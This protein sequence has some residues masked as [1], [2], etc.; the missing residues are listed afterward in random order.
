[1][2]ALISN[3]FLLQGK[4]YFTRRENKNSDKAT[5][6]RSDKG[7]KISQDEIN[8]AGSYYDSNTNTIDMAE[9]HDLKFGPNYI[10]KKGASDKFMA[11]SQTK[12]FRDAYK[13]ATGKEIINFAEAVEAAKNW[14]TIKLGENENGLNT[15]YDEEKHGPI[16]KY[17]I[18]QQGS[19]FDYLQICAYKNEGQ[20]LFKKNK[21]KG[22][23]INYASQGDVEERVPG[24]AHGRVYLPM[25]PGLADQTQVSW[26]Q[27]SMNALDSVIAGS[28]GGA[29]EGASRSSL[30]S[31]SQGFGNAA[32][33]ISEIVKDIKGPDVAA[34]AAGKMIGKNLLARGTGRAVN[35]NLELLF[36]GP[37]LRTFA[38]SY[39]F[40]PREEKESLMIKKII[41]FF[42]KAMSPRKTK[43]KI[44][45]ESPDIFKLKYIYGPR[46]GQHPFLN[47]I[48]M[49]SLQSFDVQYTPDGSYST[50]DDGSMTAYQVSLQ[51]GELNPI[52]QNDQDK[53]NIQ[54]SM[55][56]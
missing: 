21:S 7:S 1:M 10:S 47:K 11:L 56:Y 46:G 25:Q 5:V 2:A 50:Y 37:T 4:S 27:E 41:R 36:T 6:V 52:Y 35:N 19:N 43:E 33:G 39:R 20:D 45:L 16:L 40:T 34:W 18:N 49:C 38:Y 8:I 29:V 28:G 31:L 9:I 32:G 54:D 23:E 17:P 48:K 12:E 51:F 22:K 26:N 3:Y 30:D 42:K 15:M 44:F 53:D 13:K 24:P 14:D 55:G